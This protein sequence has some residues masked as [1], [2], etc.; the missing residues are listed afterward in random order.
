M[1]HHNLQARGRKNVILMSMI[2]FFKVY[3]P[4][5]TRFTNG[6]KRFQNL[7]FS[8]T[9][10]SNTSFSSISFLHHYTYAD[11]VYL[12]HQFKKKKEKEF[13]SV[14]STAYVASQIVKVD[15]TP[16]TRTE[17]NKFNACALTNKRSDIPGLTSHCL[18]TFTS[19]SMDNLKK[20]KRER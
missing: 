16:S 17:V 9:D 7:P 15:V 12:C 8:L 3:S 2:K 14:W 5:L 20:K 6:V 4:L 11:A 18:S 13:V 1:S 19:V 10:F